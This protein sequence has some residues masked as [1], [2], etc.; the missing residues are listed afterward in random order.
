MGMFDIWKL[1]LQ[2]SLPKTPSALRAKDLRLLPW[3]HAGRML[4]R[5]DLATEVQGRLA[6]TE[7]FQFDVMLPLPDRYAKVH[8]FPLATSRRLTR[9]PPLEA[10]D[11][12]F[13]CQ[14]VEQDKQFR[15]EP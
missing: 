8:L 14:P 7:G 3:G 1:F 13:L 10:I 5:H 9:K 11:S 12:T 4:R 6:N 2:L 15:L